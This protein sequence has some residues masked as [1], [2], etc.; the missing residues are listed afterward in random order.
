MSKMTIQEKEE[1]N[2]LYEYVKKDILKYDDKLVLPKI[3]VLR[4]KGLKDGKFIAN[5]KTKAL[6]NYSFEIILMTFKINKYEIVNAIYDKNKF[7]DE[8][9]MINYL[10]AIIEKK[11]NDTYSRMNRLKQSREKGESLEI[12]TSE[13]KAEY[14]HK[15]K[16]IK[17][18]RLKELL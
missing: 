2:K 13:N 3:L 4:L 15:T 6:G 18:S 8:N 11:I 12:A 5:K 10:M 1:W 9:H 17:N 7:K 14:K 16:E